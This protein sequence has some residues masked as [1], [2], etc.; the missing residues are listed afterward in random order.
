GGGGGGGGRGGGG[1][2]EGGGDRR[3]SW[4]SG[5]GRGRGLVRQA[6]VREPAFLRLLG[7]ARRVVGGLRQP[8]VRGDQHQN[9]QQDHHERDLDLDLEVSRLPQV[10]AERA[11]DQAGANDEAKAIEPLQQKDEPDS[12]HPQRV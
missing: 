11:D 7:S 12:A 4:C 1:R 10:R 2:G 9:T 5:G 6:G 8:G 3:G